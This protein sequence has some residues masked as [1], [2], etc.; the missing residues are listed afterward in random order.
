MKFLQ[1]R[2]VE[3]D[4]KIKQ[5][6]VLK[7]SMKSILDGNSSW[8]QMTLW[9]CTMTL[10]NRKV[11]RFTSLFIAETLSIWS[12]SLVFNAVLFDRIFH[13]ASVLVIAG[14]HY[15]QG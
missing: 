15:M 14:V 6:R 8:N 10:K 3:R 13:I 5:M 12:T 4:L 11:N 1:E 9:I 7:N 2:N